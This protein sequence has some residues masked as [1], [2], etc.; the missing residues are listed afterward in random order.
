[1]ASYQGVSLI[2]GGPTVQIMETRR[3]LLQLGVDVE[4]FNMWASLEEILDCDLVHLFAS[5]FDV[6]GLARHFH[7]RQLPYVVSSIFYTRRSAR[8]V[9]T[10]TTIHRLMRKIHRGVWWDYGYNRDV[11]AWAEAVLPNTREEA[12][13][14]HEGLGIPM[15]KITV[16]PNGVSESFLHGD[17]ALFRKKYGLEN[18]ILNVGHI[19]PDRKNVLAL[20]KA[21]E[22]IDHPAVIIGQVTRGGESQAIMEEARKNKK[23]LIIEGLPH[24]SPLLAS[25]YA[26]CEVF[27]LPAKFETPGIAALEAALAGAKIVITPY[28]GTR[29]YFE[30][31]AE[32]VNP[33]SIEDIR[34]GILSA[35]E[36]PR[37]DR[38][39]EHVLKNFTWDKI[40][41]KTLAVY[42]HVLSPDYLPQRGRD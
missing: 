2:R 15:E 19:G 40:A 18:F 21:L 28:G 34:R 4:L 31:M 11:C 25:A 24:D 9:R 6:Y 37:T 27:A 17:P 3:H 23:L 36:A 30:D 7:E 8:I 33:Y 32:Y 20:V 12:K 1:M 41:K 22:K 26:A 14:V 10:I 16:I 35:L 38:L 29:E 13:L 42:K 39:K 5:N